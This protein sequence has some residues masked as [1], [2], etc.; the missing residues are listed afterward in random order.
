MLFLGCDECEEKEKQ[1]VVLNNELKTKEMKWAE[2][3]TK[4]K[5]QLKKSNK[6]QQEL[7]NENQKL[8]LKKV[9]SKVGV[10]G[11]RAAGPEVTVDRHR[12]EED[13]GFRTQ[14][15]RFILY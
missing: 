2:E 1:A 6:D 9:N 11:G 14:P 7:R 5:E 3:V 10:G 12:E 13:S 4:L 8:R 15:G